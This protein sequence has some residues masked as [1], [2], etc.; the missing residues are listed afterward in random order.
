LQAATSTTSAS[1]AL[2]KNLVPTEGFEPPRPKAVVPKTTV[3]AVPPRGLD[4]YRE[5]E[6]KQSDDLDALLKLRDRR[7][8][9][10]A[11]LCPHGGRLSTETLVESKGI[12]PSFAAC[13]AAVLPLNDD[14]KL[15]G[16]RFW[17]R[18]R[19]GRVRACCLYAWLSASGCEGGIRTHITAVN[20]RVLYQ[21]SHLTKTFGTPMEIRT[22]IHGFVGHSPVR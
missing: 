16:W 9:A 3:S 15:F 11:R 21:V 18:T 20:G 10:M 1:G 4:F 8:S 5:Y 6:H 2:S 17:I 7:N 14:P 19:D 13:K 22:P 12:E